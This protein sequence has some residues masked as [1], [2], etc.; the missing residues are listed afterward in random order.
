MRTDFD[1]ETTAKKCIEWIQYY[2]K[3]TNGEN[4]I[5]GLSGGKDSAIA[6]ALCVQA[7]GKEHVIGVMMPYGHQN[8]I[9]DAYA[10][11]S[12][13]GIRTIEVNIK[14]MVDDILNGLHQILTPQTIQNVP[15]RIRMTTLYAIA[16]SNNGRVCETCNYSERLMGY[17]TLWGD[18]V[19]DFSPLGD[20]L[21]SEV[22]AIGDYL[23]LPQNLVHKT[24]SD[25]LC[26][27]TDEE[28]MGFSYDEIEDWVNC[29][30]LRYLNSNDPVSN[31]YEK[32]KWKM[33]MVN[34]PT[35]TK[36]AYNDMEGNIE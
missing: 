22:I 24:P 26:G 33:S 31:R 23:G 34:I 11:A 5:I 13:L 1:A 18:G 8:D 19:G 12:H 32:N 20:L 35:Y 25:G 14:P 29:F 28:N 16:Q 9:E 3:N 17:M 6:A 36:F 2:F 7:L 15:P 10:I 21:V 27:K 4:A 30:Y